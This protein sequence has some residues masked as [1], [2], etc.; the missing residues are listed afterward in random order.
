MDFMATNNSDVDQRER[1][2]IFKIALRAVCPAAAQEGCAS[3]SIHPWWWFRWITRRSA[4]ERERESKILAICNYLMCTEIVCFPTTTTSERSTFRTVCMC[5][6]FM[7]QNCV[8][9]WEINDFQA[10]F[11]LLLLIVNL[12]RDLLWA[13]HRLGAGGWHLYSY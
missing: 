4:E 9:I 3:C 8:L 11:L 6:G 13:I 7:V 1:K 10:A 2:S 5:S 12:T